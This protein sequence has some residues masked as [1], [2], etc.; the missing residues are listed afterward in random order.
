MSTDDHR[1]RRSFIKL[2]GSVLGAG[3]GLAIAGNASAA[4]AYSTAK[5]GAGTTACAIWCTPHQ[6]VCQDGCCCGRG[7]LFY[8]SGPCGSGPMCIHHECTSFCLSENAC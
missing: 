8:C 1:G 5:G 2:I 4:S 7:K 3:A 6:Q